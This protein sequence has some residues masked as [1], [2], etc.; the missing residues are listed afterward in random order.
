[1][2]LTVVID[3]YCAKSGLLAEWGYCG[4]LETPHGNVM[5]D[6]G[7]TGHILHH[8]LSFLKIDPQTINALVI[9]HSHHDHVSGVLDFL[10]KCPDAVI[11][12][13]KGINIERR[14]DADA[15][16]RSGGID[17]AKFPNSKIIDDYE[18]ILPNV[19]AF[20]VPSENRE[21][22]YVCCR[23][24]WEVDDHGKIVPDTF[25]D[26]VSMVVKGENGWSLLLGCAHA[27]LP[28][29]MRKACGLFDI[30]EFDTVLGGSHLC[31]VREEEYPE[32][33]DQ[34]SLFPVRHWRLN[35]CTGF[36]AAAAMAAKFK[37]VDWA[38]AGSVHI[39]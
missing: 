5:L 21:T 15:S 8:N 33:F 31:A 23:N 6:T 30:T 38:G 16:R 11:Y 13:G 18:Q 2:K 4:Y 17:L 14:G 7:G 1:M 10:F 32:W 24:M 35:H 22:R 27:G 12:A 20:R 37:D 3:N 39:L 25:E 29:I 9:S 19:Y 28:N 34:L 26:D 36:K